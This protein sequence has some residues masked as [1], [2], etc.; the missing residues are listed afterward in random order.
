MASIAP[1]T[2]PSNAMQLLIYDLKAVRT[3]KNKEQVDQLLSAAELN[4]FDDIKSPRFA[5]PTVELL[6]MAQKC[7]LSEIV[8]NCRNGKYDSLPKITDQ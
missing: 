7:Q 3:E 4:Y 5:V 1:T 2:P 8:A 6:L